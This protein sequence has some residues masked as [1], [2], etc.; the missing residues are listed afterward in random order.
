[1]FTTPGAIRYQG[2]SQAE[3]YGVSGMYIGT[4]TDGASLSVVPGIYV[5]RTPGF[6]HKVA[7]K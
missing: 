3:V 2:E 7:V 6:A 4:L 1:M 5:V